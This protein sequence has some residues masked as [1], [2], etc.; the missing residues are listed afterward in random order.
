MKFRLRMETV[1]TLSDGGLA[2]QY[3]T[4]NI[5]VK[6]HP[7]GTR[8]VFAVEVSYSDDVFNGRAQA[9]QSWD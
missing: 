6:F 4:G 8:P 1:T 7:G 3:N 2:I 5:W 9:G